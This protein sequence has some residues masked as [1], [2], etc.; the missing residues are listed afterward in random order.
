MRLGEDSFSGQAKAHS[1]PLFVAIENC[2]EFCT[3][4]LEAREC[5]AK[6]SRT[7][8]SAR[9]KRVF[10]REREREKKKKREKERKKERKKKREKII[11]ERERMTK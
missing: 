4:R 11:R 5:G 1:P 10:E 2:L 8:G 9:E 6:A 3:R 7:E